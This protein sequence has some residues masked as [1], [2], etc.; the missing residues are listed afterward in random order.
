MRRAPGPDHRV[1]ADAQLSQSACSIP[2]D[3]GN[4]FWHCLTDLS[5]PRCMNRTAGTGINALR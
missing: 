4:F 5:A 3:T 1:N 2:G